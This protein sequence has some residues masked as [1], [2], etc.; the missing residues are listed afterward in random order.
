MISTTQITKRSLLRSLVANLYGQNYKGVKEI[1]KE[2][3]LVNS[4]SYIDWRASHI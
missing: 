1:V 3:K 4:Q 2:N